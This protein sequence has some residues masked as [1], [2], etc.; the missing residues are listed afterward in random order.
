MKKILTIAAR[1]YNAVVRSKAFIISII[2]LPVMMFGSMAVAKFS[3]QVR[4]ESQ[5]KIAVIDRTPGEQIY[6]KLVDELSK[7]DDMEARFVIEHIAPA[8][9]DDAINLQ[10]FDLSERV[11]RGDLTGILEIGEKVPSAIVADAPRNLPDDE[12]VRYRTNTPAAMGFRDWAGKA[13]DRIVQ[14]ER[15]AKLS[16]SEAQVKTIQSKVAVESAGL[17]R[18]DSTGKIVYSEAERDVV[19]FLIPFGLVF[20]MFIVVVIGAVPMLQGIVEE[21]QQRI[22]EVLLG[23]VS[24]FQLMAGKVLGIV[25][26]S[27]TLIFVYL[28]GAYWGAQRVNMIEYMPTHVLAWFILFQLLSVLM[29]GSLYIAIGAA[30]TDTKEMQSLLMP[31]NL[32]MAIPLMTIMPIILSPRGMLARAMTWFPPATPFVTVARI[33]VPPG[34]SLAETLV[35]IVIVA[36]TTIVLVWASGRIF[37][38]GILMQGKGANLG[39]LFKWVVRG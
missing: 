13:I 16:L 36:I 10:R 7:R 34:M 29:Y 35:S 30:C 15:L 37:R 25:A 12:I 17:A 11:R 21:K 31:V 22:A 3:Q 28:I 23:S 1:E 19:S 2:L 18:K 8:S 39:Q 20:L 32:L 6:P 26:T 9:G 5:R 4:D 27:F 14:R 33:A 38:V 24:P